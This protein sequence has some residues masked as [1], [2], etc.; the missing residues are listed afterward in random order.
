MVQLRTCAKGPL[1]KACPR[2]PALCYP[3]AV[4]LSATAA[5]DNSV[6]MRAAQSLM[7]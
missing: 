6:L 3:A 4:G 1:R 5:A 7:N 2:I